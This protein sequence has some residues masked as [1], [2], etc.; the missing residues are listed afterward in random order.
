[1]N[2]STLEVRWVLTAASAEWLWY[3]GRGFT[4]KVRQAYGQTSRISANGL[5]WLRGERAR[6]VS[7]D[8]CPADLRRL[9]VSPEHA[10]M[11]FTECR[12]ARQM[13]LIRNTPLF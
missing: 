13:K 4:Q 5:A 12:S 3:G 6:F 11:K 9:Q 1:M 7:H 2:A 10:A 8:L